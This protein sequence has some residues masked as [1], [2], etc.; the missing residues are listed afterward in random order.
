MWPNTDHWAT[1][2]TCFVWGQ[3]FECPCPFFLGTQNIRPWLLF[4]WA[5]FQGVFAVTNLEG[6]SNVSLKHRLILAYSLPIH[7]K[8]QLFQAQWP[9]V[10]TQ[11]QSMHSV[12]QGPYCIIPVRFGA[13]RT[14]ANSDSPVPAVPWVKKAYVSDQ[15]SCVFCQHRQDWSFWHFTVPYLQVNKLVYFFFIGIGRIHW[16]IFIFS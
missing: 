10:V 7:K 14:S 9:S 3:G 13:R 1:G 5:I 4:T 12:H 11:T 6:W 15:K 2:E 8:E 16:I